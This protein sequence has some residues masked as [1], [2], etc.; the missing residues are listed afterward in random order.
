MQSKR[1]RNWPGLSSNGERAYEVDVMSDEASSELP[2]A[3]IKAAGRLVICSGSVATER[4][5]EVVISIKGQRE[6]LQVIFY[7]MDSA[8]NSGASEA[9]MY[10]ELVGENILRL[11][12]SDFRNP[13][14]AGAQPL[15][16]GTLDGQSLYLSW[17]TY[18]LGIMRILHYT[19]S[20][21]A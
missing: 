15:S 3:T 19:F 20:V 6:G 14:G 16:I 7:F 2:R 21:G 13:L 1:L 18:S 9:R 12:L 17:A 10:A 5:D 4:N 11:N 8:E